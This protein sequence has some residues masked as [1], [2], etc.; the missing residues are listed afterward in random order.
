MYIIALGW[1]A[2]VVAE[3]AIRDFETPGGVNEAMMA[4]VGFLFAGRQAAIAR[5]KED[6]DG[7]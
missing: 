3:I 5:Q 4:L 6:D 2:T 1:V 7:S